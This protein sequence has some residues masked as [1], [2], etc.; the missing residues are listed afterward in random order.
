MDNH[1]IKILMF[2]I[3][4]S[5]IQVPAFADLD[6][7]KNNTV[8]TSP[9]TYEPNKTYQFNITWQNT[10]DPLDTV[11]FEWDGTKEIPTGSRTID[12][13]TT[14]FY[15]D[16][17]D[18]S[19][20]EYGWEYK[21]IAN[22]TLGNSNSTDDQFYIIDKTTPTITLLLDNN[23]SETVTFDM[24]WT[25]NFTAYSDV[26]NLN[27][28]LNTTLSGWTEQN[29]T[30]I[31]YLSTLTDSEGTY[32]VTAYT[33]GN[34]NYSSTNLTHYLVVEYRAPSCS[35]NEYPTN[36]TNYSL[37]EN[38]H[39]NLTCQDGS[40]E[41]VIFTFNG[42]EI[43]TNNT[44]I[45]ANTKVFNATLIDLPANETGYTYNW[46]AEDSFGDNSSTGNLTYVIE[47]GSILHLAIDGEES[48]KAI[49]DGTLA[50]ITCWTNDTRID[51]TQFKLERWVG[52]PLQYQDTYTN[53]SAYNISVNK[54]FYLADDGTEYRCYINN[55][56]IAENYINI[57]RI[58]TVNPISTDDG[59]DD[60][61]P[62]SSGGTL[63]ISG[64]ISIQGLTSKLTVNAGESK[65][66]TFSLKNTYDLS[67]Y[68][69]ISISGISDTWYRLDKK[70]LVRV[71][72]DSS[73]TITL[74]FNIP[75]DAEAKD[76][77][78]R[79]TVRGGTN[80][81]TSFIL[82]VNPPVEEELTIEQNETLEAT[83]QT[84]NE[85]AA[86]PTGLF[87]FNLIDP[88]YIVLIVGAM[89]CILIFIF[90][91]KI[92]GTLLI[93]YQSKPIKEERIEVKSKLEEKVIKKKPEKKLKIR[94]PFSGLKLRLSLVKEKKEKKEKK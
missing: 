71:F 44:T 87:P 84:A 81:Q 12:A 51:G 85:T 72:G 75:E 60:G 82:T 47:K 34:E 37:G 76:Y 56:S 11:L 42:T 21:W 45:D 93:R 2:L 39:F 64:S 54:T 79:V 26:S 70:T 92:T 80:P 57:S 49:T 18:L 48:N 17:I 16:K 3:L 74:T 77:T 61:S 14:E 58:V 94:S 89:A 46:F 13:N 73:E 53:T 86:S 30:T 35:H 20:N 23:D 31:I 8:P 63:P 62:P 32:N 4:L 52:Y 27:I 1:L 50:N 24:N 41:T 78:V 10:T 7:S 88:T 28:K 83:N 38:Y 6:Y 15:V 19:A 33:D 25:V 55:S 40:L 68:V 66:T 59:G 36:G 29:G 9:T 90:R 22:D 91:K 5:F 67:F 69:N 43:S 65:S